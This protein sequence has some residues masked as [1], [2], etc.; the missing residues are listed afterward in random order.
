VA[1][2]I[3]IGIPLALG[4]A[5]ALLL[6]V[7]GGTTVAVSLAAFGLAAASLPAGR[8]LAHRH[9]TRLAAVRAEADSEVARLTQLYAVCIPV[10][11]RQLETVRSE[12][13]N[14]VAQ[15]A[16]VFGEITRKLDKAIGPSRLTHTAGGDAQQEILASLARNGRE[17]E[18]LVAALRLLQTSKQRI[19][20]EIGSE[21]ARLKENASDIRQI[22]LH[23]RMVSLNATIEAARAGQ[24]GRPFA[25]VIT[26]MRELAARTA[27]ASELFSRHTGRLHAMVGAAFQEQAQTDSRVVSIAGAE[28]LVNKVVANSAA[29]MRQLTREIEAME[30]ERKDVREDISQV[31]VSLQFQDRVSQILSHVTSNLEEMQGHIRD[32]RQDALDDHQWMERMAS[33]YSTHEEFENHRGAAMSTVEPGAA[34]TF[35]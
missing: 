7:A 19:V 20:E 25:V 11:M 10:W 22:A 33:A 3:F 14:E 34:V 15:L 2:N 27:E 4:L 6:L 26:D 21:A 13:D 9:A 23:I 35:F 1:A 28:E 12:A 17:L 29:T 31:L 32:G 30:Q 8:A 18:T 24:A 5:G 16:R